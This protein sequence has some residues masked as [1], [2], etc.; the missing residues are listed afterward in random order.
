[1]K[2]SVIWVLVVIVVALA[3]WYWWGHRAPGTPYVASPAGQATTTASAYQ[4]TPSNLLLGPD[5]TG[6][7]AFLIGFNG[8]PVY[9]YDHDSATASACTGGCAATWPPYIIAAADTANALTALESPVGGTASTITRADGSLQVTYNGKPLYFYAS[10]TA[11]SG[12]TGDGVG[13]VWHVAKP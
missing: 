1:M 11:S 6:A 9:T 7:S 13:G 5:G 3:G 10:D 2:Q 12:P 8:M 4:Y